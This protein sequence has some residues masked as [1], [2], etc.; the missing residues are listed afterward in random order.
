MLTGGIIVIV[1]ISLGLSYAQQSNAQEQLNQELSQAQL[2]LAKSAPDTVSSQKDEL[3]TRLAESRSQFEALK[4]KISPVIESIESSD[5][6]FDIAEKCGVEVIGTRSNPPDSQTL[7][8]VNYSITWLKVTIEGNIDNINRFIRTWTE[9]NH[10]GVVR[11]VRITTLGMI[12]V[13]EEATGDEGEE[14]TGDEDEED[15]GDE[16]E[17]D[18]GDTQQEISSAVIEMI[19]YTYEG[20]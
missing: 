8:G 14:D 9:E 10:T 1:V 5:C 11:S 13:A 19:I 18:T 17:E 4:V 2:I 16:D 6:L 12:E 20:S 3:E 15:T 7:N